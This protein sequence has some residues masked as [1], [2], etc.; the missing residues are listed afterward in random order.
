MAA[1]AELFYLVL[2]VLLT[3]IIHLILSPTQAPEEIANLILCSGERKI[4]AVFFAD[5]R[6]AFRQIASKFHN[7]ARGKS[8]LESPDNCIDTANDVD[9]PRVRRDCWKF[10]VVQVQG[11]VSRAKAFVVRR[12]KKTDSCACSTVFIF[13]RHCSRF[14]ARWHGSA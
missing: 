1:E 3:L 4:S 13:G 9:R 8:V 12:F 7:P 2:L 6:S 5:V 10:F 11:N 14:T